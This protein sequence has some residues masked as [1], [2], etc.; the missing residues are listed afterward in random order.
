MYMY[1]LIKLTRLLNQF[2]KNIEC[3]F[4]AVTTACYWSRMFVNA[5]CNPFQLLNESSCK[6]YSVGFYL[7]VFALSTPLPTRLR[8]L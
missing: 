3:P 7:F 8:L 1:V 5:H 2:L 4:I 6:I